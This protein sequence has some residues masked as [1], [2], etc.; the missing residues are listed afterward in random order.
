MISTHDFVG[1]ALKAVE[2]GEYEQAQLIVENA[3]VLGDASPAL[4]GVLLLALIEQGKV[5][6]ALALHAHLTALA[7]A[8]DPGSE[9]STAL[10]MLSALGERAELRKSAERWL[11]RAGGA[12]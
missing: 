6:Q 8:L 5:E 10:T 4:G 9:R 2:L 3:A 7:E 12:R 11:P 1:M